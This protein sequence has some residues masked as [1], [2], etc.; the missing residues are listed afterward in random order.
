MRMKLVERLDDGWFPLEEITR[1]F[2]KIG[3]KSNEAAQPSEPL[4]LALSALEKEEE[5]EG[6]DDE[7]TQ[8]HND[9]VAFFARAFAQAGAYVPVRNPVFQIVAGK[10]GRDEEDR[11]LER[12]SQEG[13]SE[14]M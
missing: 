11:V 12:H 2:K 4:D 1:S 14:R 5:E 13:A 9:G 8:L 10:N 7:L 6:S 3:E